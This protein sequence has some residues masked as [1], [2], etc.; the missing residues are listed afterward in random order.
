VNSV[1]V[2]IQHIAEV[3]PFDSPH[4]RTLILFG[5][6][7]AAI[8]SKK[9]PANPKVDY[10]WGKGLQRFD[11]YSSKSHRFGGIVKADT[12]VQNYCCCDV[13]RYTIVI[14]M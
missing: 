2:P 14:A 7:K 3:S 1:K 9:L 11:S 13:W 10:L 12:Q 8:H 5:G 4:A 6:M